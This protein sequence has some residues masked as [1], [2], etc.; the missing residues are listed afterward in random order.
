MMGYCQTEEATVFDEASTVYDRSIF[1]GPIIHTNGWGAF[2]AFGKSRTAFKYRIWQFEVVGMKHV[3]EIKSYNTLEDSRSYIFGKLNSF[4][5]LRPSYGRRI[6]SFEKIRKSGVSV[7]YSWRIGPSL[8]FTKPVYLQI[9]VPP[10]QYPYQRVIVER[11][12]PVLHNETNIIGRAGILKG[13]SELKL[14]PGLYG[15]I[16]ANFEYDAERSGIKGVEVGAT[17]DFYPI[18]PIEIM[19]FSKNY[20]LFINC[21]V[22]L[23][24]G[25]KFNR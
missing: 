15:A 17:V 14:H 11:Y 13:F 3:K 22:S 1:G 20:R 23:Q 21:Y 4:F 2:L 10:D 8:G 9:G 19:A 16:A 18:E 24:F 6:I 12:N 7:G 25:K 5:I